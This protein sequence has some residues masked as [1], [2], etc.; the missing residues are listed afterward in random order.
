VKRAGVLSLV[1]LA[2]ASLLGWDW[3]SVDLEK[4]ASGGSKLI[5]AAAG[6]S[7]ES[8][9]RLGRE[10]AANLAARYGLVEDKDKVLYLNRVGLIAARLSP[11]SKLPYH[12]AIL[13]SEEFNAFAAPGGYIFITEGLLNF[14]QDEAELAGVLA[15]EISHVSERHIVKAIQKANV[16]G[17]GQD[18]AAASGYDTGAW[19]QLTDFSINLL[20]KGH[21]RKD[22]LQADRAGTLLA[23]STGYDPRGLH[24]TVARIG[25]LKGV[26]AVYARFSSTHPPAHER[27][28]EI[29]KALKQIKSPGDIRL[30]DRYAKYIPRK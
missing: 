22:E 8:E 5:K 9:I 14:L 17:A 21:S 29:N 20:D 11:R 30:A 16:L 3:Q 25:L 7:D 19:A 2:A 23:A 6:M 12:F 1:F 27:V 26:D 10:V 13:K 4:V 24:D 15:H 18:L 28:K